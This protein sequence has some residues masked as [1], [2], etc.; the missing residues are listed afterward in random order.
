MVRD[1]LQDLHST[2]QLRSQQLSHVF[3]SPHLTLAAN[4]SGVEAEQLRDPDWH[5]QE[6]GQCQAQQGWRHKLCARAVGL[7][8]LQ[9]LLGHLCP[10]GS[11]L[12]QSRFLLL[13]SLRG[14][15]GISAE[16]LSNA[17]A[18]LAFQ[19]QRS[20]PGWDSKAAFPQGQE[21]S[22]TSSYIFKTTR[23]F[24]CLLA[25]QTNTGLNPNAGSCKHSWGCDHSSPST[26]SSGLSSC[27]CTSSLGKDN[28]L[29]LRGIS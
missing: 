24:T 1:C 17:T 19:R 27:Y 4:Y 20:S 6:L 5:L 18:R 8:V 21:G 28:F 15:S 22:K 2:S 9:P 25:V 29:C 16:I 23:G 14:D 11:S 13:P 26:H 7:R 12:S 10:L 3:C